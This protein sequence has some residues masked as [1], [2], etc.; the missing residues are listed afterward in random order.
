MQLLP[1]SVLD[2]KNAYREWYINEWPFVYKITLC[3]LTETVYLTSEQNTFV[4]LSTDRW[5]VL[6]QA[7]DQEILKIVVLGKKNA[8]EQ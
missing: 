3:S 4:F 8:I 1:S 6:E 7:S 2:Q 5:S